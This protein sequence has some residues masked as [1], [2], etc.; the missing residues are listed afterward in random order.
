[1]RCRRGSVSA[2]RSERVE[3]D[4]PD[5]VGRGQAHDVGDRVDRRERRGPRLDAERGTPSTER[6]RRRRERTSRPAAVARSATPARG[7]SPAARPRRAAP[8]AARRSKAGR[9]RSGPAPRAVAW[10]LHRASR[11]GSWFRIARSSSCSSRPGSIPKPSTSLAPRRAVDVERVGLAARPVQGEHQPQANGSWSGCCAASS[12]ELADELA[13]P[14]EGELRVEALLERRQQDLLQPPGRESGRT[15]RARGLQARAPRQRAS[16]SRCSS[17]GR[18]GLAASP[19]PGPP[20]RSAA[21]TASG[22]AARPRRWSTYPGARVSSL[23]SSPSALAELGDLA[24]H[25]RRRRDGR[26]PGVELVGE[27]VDRDDPVRVQEQD[28]ERRS[29]LRPAELNRPVG[30]DDLERPQ[31]PELEHR[32]TVAVR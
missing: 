31:D 3:E 1:M 10:R 17:N 19:A 26:A 30:S 11:A 13:V 4:E 27:P 8:R 21:R 32:R 7:A 16:A 6:G 15:A 5:V 23:A 20:P 29:L 28:R 22:R 12:L 2:S 9:A 24:V 18:L 14:A 25:L